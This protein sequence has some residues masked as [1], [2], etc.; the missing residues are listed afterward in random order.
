[1][2][3]LYERIGGED[4]VFAAASLLYDKLLADPQVG[5]FFSGLDMDAQ[6]RKQSAF[7]AWAF[8][9]PDRYEFRPL[10]EAHRQ[11]VRDRG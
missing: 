10:G 5:S 6:V 3:T 11:L 2:T 7:L 4:A 8:G 9:A 1:M